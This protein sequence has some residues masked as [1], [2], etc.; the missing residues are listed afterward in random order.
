MTVSRALT[1]TMLLGFIGVAGCMSDYF[2]LPIDPAYRADS[3]LT[4]KNE[5]GLLL[6]AESLFP[7]EKSEKYLRWDLKED[8]YVPVVLYTNNRGKNSYL[9]MFSDVQL[10][11]PNGT[12]LSPTKAWDV[13]LDVKIPG[14]FVNSESDMKMNRDY[15]DKD[16]FRGRAGVRIGTGSNVAG[17]LFFRIPGDKEMTNLT[18]AVLKLHITREKSAGHAESMKFKTL[19][20]LE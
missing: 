16:F 17:V 7:T 13:F 8:G 10:I 6:A 1:M 12:E 2:T 3:Y 4:C 18:D 14:L 19:V 20:A 11:L 5:S 15:Q 9:V